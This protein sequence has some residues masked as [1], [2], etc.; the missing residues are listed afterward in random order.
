MDDGKTGVLFVTHAE[1]KGG[2]EQS[3]IHLINFLDTSKYRIYLL[4]PESASYLREIRTA[5]AHFPLRLNSI[6]KRLGFGYAETVLRIRAFVKKNRIGIVHANGWR[7]P[8]YAAPLKFLADC[9][10]VWHHRDHTH[11]WMF[12]RVL[13]KFFDQVICISRFVADSV[14]GGN[15]TIIYNGVDPE[16]AAAPK[17]RRFMEDD[18]LVIGTF[19]RIVEWK[20]YDLVIE[21]VKKLADD[22]KYNWKL[23]IVGDTS[24][25]GSDAYYDGLIRQ[26]EAYGL[27]E[28]VVFYGYTPAP[29]DVMKA[30]DLTVNFSL[31]EPFGRVII[32]SLLAQTPVIVADSGGAPEIIRETGGGF[33]VKDGDVDALY[34]VIRRVYD[35]AVNHEALAGEG[36]AG[37]IERFHMKAIARKVEGTYR[38]LQARPEASGGG[39]IA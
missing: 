34:R 25:D 20:R 21:A 3:L 39:V 14:E 13:P 32:E 8:W 37:V 18:T 23:L 28:N 17:R 31:N 26:V 19:G 10:L 9:K 38:S 12:N 2:A 16:L 29:I 1:K 15:K 5:Y 11:L 6:K 33:I 30:C 27:E 7:A 24:V 22:K 36:Y 35:K 4:C